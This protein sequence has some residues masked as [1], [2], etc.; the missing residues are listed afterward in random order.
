MSDPL[1]EEIWRV[2][3][4]LLIECGG[5]EGLLKEVQRLEKTHLQKAAAAKTRRRKSAVATKPARSKT[6]NSKS[7]NLA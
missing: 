2:R 5:M 7:G 3:E 1:M 4:Q 6:K